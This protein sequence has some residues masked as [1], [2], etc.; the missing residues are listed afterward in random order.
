MALRQPWSR[1]QRDRIASELTERETQ[2][3]TAGVTDALQE[4]Y[5]VQN[6]SPTLT[7]NAQEILSYL[8]ESSDSEVSQ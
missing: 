2:L 5:S 8:C 3:K 1:T 4:I 7:G 6:P